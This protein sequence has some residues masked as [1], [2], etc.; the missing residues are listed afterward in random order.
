MKN[1]EQTSAMTGSK[2]ATD[3]LFNRTLGLM[4]KALNLRQFRQ[5]MTAGNLANLDTP[6]YRVRD[7]KFEKIMAEAMRPPEGQLAVRQTNSKHMPVRNID[8][9]YQAAQKNVKYGIYGQDEKGG[10]VVDIDQEMTKLAKNHLMF[11]TT[12][13]MLAKEYELL[14][15]SISEGGR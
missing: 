7:I 6:G 5:G 9:A 2:N 11:N 13:Q 10:D 14:K 12:V 4:G 8:Q 1:G 3:K 15:Y